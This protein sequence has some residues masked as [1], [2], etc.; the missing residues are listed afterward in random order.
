MALE[1]PPVKDAERLYLAVW[2]ETSS[3]EFWYPEHVPEGEPQKC[4][5]TPGED[6][7]FDDTCVHEVRNNTVFRR[8]ILFVDVERHDIPW[9]ARIVHRFFMSIARFLPAIQQ[10]KKKMIEDDVKIDANSEIDHVDEPNTMRTH[11]SMNAT[12]QASENSGNSGNGNV[13]VNGNGYGN[14][15]SPPLSHFSQATVPEVA[16]YKRARILIERQKKRAEIIARQRANLI[17]NLKNSM[18]QAMKEKE[19]AE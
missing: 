15:D 5:W 14:P 19:T 11:C 3:H 16:P 6:F 10:V 13:N 12:K 9:Y 8:I 1:V 7:I 4:F 17:N 18:T 2:P